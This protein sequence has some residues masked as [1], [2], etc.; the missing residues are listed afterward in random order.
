MKASKKRSSKPVDRSTEERIKEAARTLFTRKGFASVRTRDIAEEAGINLALLNYY[1]RSKEKL[2]E[3]IMMENI[4]HFMVG[5]KEI[6][7]NEG[8]TL[9][10][11][12]ELI[13]SH[14]IDMLQRHPHLPMFILGELRR[15]PEAFV[16]RMG[17][18]EF[19]FKSSYFRQLNEEVRRKRT[20]ISPLHYFVN[21]IA[22]IVFPFVGSPILKIVG[23]M[24]DDE[25]NSL[26]NERKT[27]ISKWAEVMLNT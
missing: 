9:K 17:I 15:H 27:L 23:D 18:R 2:F 11:K 16:Q 4:Q 13:A 1:F 7:I 3:L 22:L 12:N 10:E 6:L 19:L 8:T 25:F 5:V 21:T 24:S 26:M 14:Y 20:G